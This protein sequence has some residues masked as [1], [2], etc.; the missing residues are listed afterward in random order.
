M[1][2]EVPSNRDF[3]AVRGRSPYSAVYSS[4]PAL[5]G[6]SPLPRLIHGIRCR[7]GLGSRRFG[8]GVASLAGALVKAARRYFA[9]LIVCGVP[10]DR[11]WV[12]LFASLEVGVPVCLN[13]NP[14][15]G[16]LPFGPIGIGG[17]PRRSSSSPQSGCSSRIVVRAVA[18]TPSREAG[19]DGQTGACL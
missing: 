13:R 17:V 9:S 1:K 10:S 18:R 5:A 2:L 12:S 7:L 19:A 8:V 4:T 14:F 16:N 3:N 11:G 15:L 6:T